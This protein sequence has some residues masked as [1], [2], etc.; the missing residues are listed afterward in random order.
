[1]GRYC[2]GLRLAVGC[3]VGSRH[4]LSRVPR[5][6]TRSGVRCGVRLLRVRRGHWLSWHWG[7]CGRSVRIN[8]ISRVG[9]IASGWCARVSLHDWRLLLL[10]SSLRSVH[11]GVT[12]PLTLLLASLSALV[13]LSPVLSVLHVQSLLTFNVSPLEFDVSHDDKFVHGIK[14][15]KT[16]KTKASSFA[17]I[18][19]S[20]E[21]TL[22]DCTVRLKELFE[23]TLV[24]IG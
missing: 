24:G 14:V 12:R 17:R 4:G 13:I 20:L 1:M 10:L 22:R 15:F 6:W 7:C 11:R 9:R 3:G 23:I 16:D 2:I 21:L 18:L 8:R 5:G 19:V